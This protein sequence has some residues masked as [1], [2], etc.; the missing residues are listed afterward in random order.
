MYTDATMIEIEGAM[1]QAWEAFH[2]YRRMS[3]KQRADFMRA[4]GK[5]IEN[6]GDEL[7]KITHEETSLP[8]AR[9][10]NERARTIFQL[11]SYA[12]A[13]ERGDWLEARIDT[14]VP[15]K[16][17]PKPD[18]RKMLIPL[19][20]VVVFGAANF[21]Y[22]YSTAGGDTACAFAAGCPVI[23]KAHPAHA[24][25]SEMVASAILKAAA[26][27][28][29][30]AGIFTHLHGF[31]F[32]VGKALVTHPHTKAV[33]FTG[34]FAGGK[35]LFDWANQRKEP[36]P[37]FAE[38]S[39][40]N[41]VF[42]LPE[43]MKQAAAELAKMYA[44]SITLGVGQFCTNPG[45]IIG[46]D[47]DDLNNFINVLSEEIRKTAPGNMLN[48][49]I[50]KN[51]VEKRAI[52][53][54]QEEVETIAVSEQDPIVNQG[55]PTIASASAQAFFNNP[56]LHHEVFGPFSIVIRCKDTNE[57]SEVAKHLDGQLTAT[58][59]ATD[60]DVKDHTGLVENV[61]NICGRLIMNSVPTGVEVCLS[62]QHGGPF[63][64]TTDSRFTSVGADG[65]KRFARPI[66]FQNWS[67]DL[68]PE[69]LKNENPLQIWR[70]IN[71]EITK[72]AI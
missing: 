62:M 21:P 44:G 47:N 34:S 69:E 49:G 2:V 33:G 20:P 1:Q 42:L 14:A 9:L 66:C 5:E 50:F 56:I 7:L 58:L 40:I 43:K 6:L 37:V 65:I 3:L 57:M 64:A 28:Y 29:M 39:S 71:N 19:G 31:S 17:P 24:R 12:D 51:Y 68:L 16:N 41:P 8:E 52:A 36:I 53:L 25:T 35:Q 48:P 60:Q 55:A 15:D 70:T 27:C 54:S 67:N 46:I 10:R 72:T 30:P 23:V 22:A 32:E 4:I 26:N 18:L 38:M 13:C 63:P 11:N 59:M 45:L 61:K